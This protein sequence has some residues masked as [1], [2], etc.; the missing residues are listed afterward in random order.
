MYLE[1]SEQSKVSGE[2]EQSTEVML[3]EQCQVPKAADLTSPSKGSAE[4]G[5]KALVEY[6]EQTV[7]SRE[8]DP[9][10][11]CVEHCN[12]NIDETDSCTY[13]NGHSESFEQY[14]ASEGFFE[15]DQTLEKCE[16]L[17]LSQPFDECAQH[18]ECFKP[19][20][21][22]EHCANHSLTSKCSPCC[23]QCAGH[24]QLFQQ[25]QPSDQQFES[26]D[27]EP[28]KCDS[29]E[30]CE[31]SDFI[32]ECADNLELMQQ[33][34]PSAQ[35]CE[36]FDSEPDT[37]TEDSEQCEM[38]GFTH[39][40]SDS[41]DL[42]D[43]G[44]ELCECDEIQNQTESTD[45]DEESYPPEPTDEQNE[46]ESIDETLIEESCRLAGD[47][48]SSH[49]HTP[50]HV[51]FD[52]SEDVPFASGCCE[53]HQLTEENSQQA[54]MST[55]HCEMCKTDYS[56]PSHEYEPTEQRTTSEQRNSD[57]TE[58]CTEE[59][60]TSDCSSIETKSF[61]TC[62]EGSIPSDPYSDSS[63]ESEKGAQE[64]SSDEQTQ[65]ES[66]EDD[67]EIEQS[68]INESNEDKKKTPTVD[69][70]VEDY[71][72]LFDRADYH[73]HAFAL[74]QRYISCFDGGDIHDHLYVDVQD[75][76][77]KLDKN[78][79]KFK[80]IKEEIHTCFDAPEE[81]CEDTY[82]E[83]ASL[84][85]DT[86]TGSCES[87]KQPEDW[88]VESESSLAEDEV[89]ENESEA[90]D[91]YAEYCEEAEEDGATYDREAYAFDGHVSQICN[92]E[93][94]EV[95][96]SSGHGESMCAPCAEDISVE[97]DAY[98]DEVSEA[99]NSESLGGRTSTIGHIQTNVTDCTKD[100]KD[101]PEDKVFIAC[102][103]I[104]P[105]WSLVDHEENEGICETGV[106]EYYA[107]QIKSIQL[108]VQQEYQKIHGKAN[109]DASRGE[110]EDGL[111]S[112][113]K[114]E[115]QKHEVCP[116]E[117]KAVRFGIT[118][119]IELSE[120]L[121]NC[122]VVEKT[123]N[124]QTPESKEDGFS[125]SSREIK[126]PLGI[127]HSVSELA[128]NDG[129][130]AHML[131]RRTEENE[132]SEKSRDSEEEQSDDESFEP[133]ECEHCIPPIEQV[134]YVFAPQLKSIGVD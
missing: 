46:T 114:T 126:P 76:A 101:E 88:I 130:D 91:L 8:M 106:E 63:G 16:T 73:G 20:K 29:F 81:T 34:E 13:C 90:H 95:C 127:I 115:L 65:W 93:E 116:E 57:N 44:T 22:P 129:R 79:Y 110:R 113:K 3:A 9:S 117:C 92:E 59:D 97:G 32:P 12:M 31:M 30:Q 7:V 10:I 61:K 49:C 118:E 55:D 133:C 2:G 87:E 120:N 125:E 109:G 38:T 37:S 40:I 33:Y 5:I 84:R 1:N 134:L 122:S 111:L 75:K 50:V 25:C 124:E 77:Q 11:L 108:S 19:C 58:F 35:L 48:N 39:N 54:D 21:S 15:S 60:G 53:T 69:I 104:E 26:F 23:K 24:L 82:E 14:S 68:K 132:A 98:E 83:D 128:K 112:L 27:F 70:V 4:L 18:R 17:G 86:S 52:D 28:D 80:E 102:S 72:D 94:A 47:I 105:Y 42:L 74:R 121:A 99:Q 67:E 107:Y 66:F 6:T 100:D 71:F 123:T 41:V 45:E 36:C 43:C 85:D 103:E 64:D 78:G 62:P 96:P 56:E 131:V 89:E 51:Y 119:I